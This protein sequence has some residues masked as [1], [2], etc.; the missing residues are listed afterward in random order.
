MVSVVAIKRSYKALNMISEGIRRSGDKF[1]TVSD[2][3]DPAVQIA[4]CYIQTNMLKPKYIASDML[5]PYKFILDSKKPFLVNESPSFRRVPKGLSYKRYGWYS[6]K[7]SDGLFGH[8]NCPSDRWKKFQNSTGVTIKDWSSPGD[9]ILIMGQK[10]GDSSL[11]PLY[12][13]GY[14]SFNE[15]L[16]EIVNE[17]RKYSDREIVIRPHPKNQTRGYKSAKSVKGKNVT[18]SA[19]LKN[20]ADIQT[21]LEQDLADAYCVVTYNSLSAVESVCDGIPTFTLD[22]GSMAWPVG[23]KDLSQIE[24]LNY[25]IDRTQWCY[26]IAYTQWNNKECKTGEAWAHLKPLIF[27]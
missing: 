17:I 4:D 24:S 10:E 11:M 1:C 15:W 21:S 5:V 23:H 27:K 22:N 13:N 8:Q 12:E 16:Q 25:S 6:Y 18:I 9:K 19:N 14:T 20:S 7:W 3:Q 26:D 2:I